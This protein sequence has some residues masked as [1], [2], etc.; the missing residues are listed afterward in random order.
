MAKISLE[1]DAL[2][3][4][5]LAKAAEV[6]AGYLRNCGLTVSV[7]QASRFMMLCRPQKVEA[8]VIDWDRRTTRVNLARANLPETGSVR[9]QITGFSGPFPSKYVMNPSEPIAPRGKTDVVFGD[10]KLASVVFR[11]GFDVKTQ[12][13]QL[14]LALLCRL[15][16]QAKPTPLNVKEAERLAKQLFALRSQLETVVK[17]LDAKDAKRKTLQQQ[18]DQGG[19][20]VRSDDRPG[21][22]VQGG[23]QGRADTL[24]HFQPTW[25]PADRP[26]GDSIGRCEGGGAAGDA[27][28]WGRSRRRSG[29]D[30]VSEAVRKLV[31]SPRE[32]VRVRASG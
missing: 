10:A 32:R 26:A 11:I 8:V 27:A 24:P 29:S 23:Q 15:P 28:S 5:W 13:A 9:L 4:R 25:R 7:G 21:R 30:P 19:A 12:G 1:Q 16:G 2:Q 22:T 18:L 17:S 14:D 3:F 31:P 20:V 6:P